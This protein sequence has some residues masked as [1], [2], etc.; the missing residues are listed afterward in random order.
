MPIE[1]RR[2]MILKG[3]SDMAIR[4]QCD[5][6]GISRGTVYYKPRGP[7]ASNLAVMHLIDEQY[8]ATPY[9]GVERMTDWLHRI[10]ITIGHNRVR[11]LM[12]LMGL[13]AL[14]PKPRLSSPS[15]QEHRTYPYLLAGR[16][17]DRPDDVWAADIAYIR[18]RQGFVYLTAVMDWYSRYILSWSL[19]TTLNAEFCVE[20]LKDALAISKPEIFNTDQGS[21]FTCS[22]FIG[23]LEE[24]KVTISMNGKGRA[25]DNIFV[26]RL[27]RTVKYEEVYLKDY[28]GVDEARNSLGQYLRVY[29]L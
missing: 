18:S 20:A 26:E 6:L 16:T 8:T 28:T 19:S 5:L 25:S 14:Y 15:A 27:W 9:Y 23:V 11:R 10:G 7:K 17:I 2:V 4:Q 21:Q 13:E 22:D 3:D 1:V 12:R 29:N 24:A